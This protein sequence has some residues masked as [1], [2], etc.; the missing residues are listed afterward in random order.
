MKKFKKAYYPSWLV[1]QGQLRTIENST[2]VHKKQVESPGKETDLPPLTN[3][4]I[5]LT[6]NEVMQNNILVLSK[7]RAAMQQA[8]HNFSGEPDRSSADRNL[9]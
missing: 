2:S 7:K 1:D 5:V 6:H 3:E 9:R 4:R 8:L